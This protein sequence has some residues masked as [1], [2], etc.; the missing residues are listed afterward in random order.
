MWLQSYR[1]R[2]NVLSHETPNILDFFNFGDELG[3]GYSGVVK[4]CTDVKQGNK[5]ACKSIKKDNLDDEGDFEDVRLEISVMQRLKSHKHIVTLKNVFEDNNHVHLIMELCEGGD[6]FDEIVKKGPLNE[7]SA[8]HI[9][10]Q[11]AEAISFCHTKGV[12]HRDVKPE[13]ILLVK[14][15]NRK[16]KG[17]PRDVTIPKG[18]KTDSERIHVKLGDFGL[19]LFLGPFQEASGFAG[20]PYYVAPEVLSQTWYGKEAD[21]WSLGVVLYV[22]L[23]G[24]FPFPG[25]T[26]EKLYNAIKRGKLNFNYS[27]WP[28]VSSLAKSLI[29][30]MLT[31]DPKLR[32]TAL[33]IMQ[34]PWI[35]SSCYDLL[36]KEVTSPTP[37]T[38]TLHTVKKFLTPPPPNSEQSKPGDSVTL[39]IDP[40]DSVVFKAPSSP[41]PSLPHLNII[42]SPP[43][44]PN[45]KQ[46]NFFLQEI[47]VDRTKTG[48]SD[49][50][51]PG[52][53]F[54]TGVSPKSVL[55]EIGSPVSVLRGPNSDS[56]RETM[57]DLGSPS[58]P[59]TP[60]NQSKN[61][62]QV[63]AEA[64]SQSPTDDPPSWVSSSL[65]RYYCDGI[66]FSI[67]YCSKA[68]GEG[69]FVRRSEEKTAD[70]NC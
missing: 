11:M 34:H 24:E 47:V 22:I 46:G 54:T 18:N 70:S 12:M 44:S 21:I 19:A 64:S 67:K 13:N 17:A 69:L 25:S 4:A 51:S 45:K 28:N 5:F 20:S 48:Y 66:T 38:T 29:R 58:N 8:A 26:D 6:L 3:T 23:S 50:S 33:E 53:S 63:Q 9:I 61:H 52:H 31:V 57:S 2:P 41:K 1:R 68:I 36:N 37:P 32:P 15:S 62:S 59:S 65:C 49:S 16:E 27:P 35:Q 7:V 56:D 42:K 10:Y 39:Q 14:K 40:V 30:S 60:Q 55:P 43:S